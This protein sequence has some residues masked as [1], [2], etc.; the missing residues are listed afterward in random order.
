MSFLKCCLFSIM[1][2]SCN[3]VVKTKTKKA[4]RFCHQSFCAVCT[5]IVQCFSLFPFSL[6]FT[7]ILDKRDNRVNNP[8]FFLFITP[9]TVFYM[10]LLSHCWWRGMMRFSLIGYINWQSGLEINQPQPHFFH[11]V[12][13]SYDHCWCSCAWFHK[14][15]QL[16]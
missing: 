5:L 16:Y 6:R 7:G 8:P 13:F 15:N 3:P 14:K 1:K 2:K 9:V 4:K 12:Y 11:S 10:H